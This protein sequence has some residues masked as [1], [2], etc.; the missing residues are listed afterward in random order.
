[1]A[2]DGRHSHACG[3]PDR[4]LSWSRRWSHGFRRFGLAHR[5]WQQLSIAG[6][7][8]YARIRPDRFLVSPR[9]GER[10]TG[11]LATYPQ[12]ARQGHDKMRPARVQEW[13][14]L[15]LQQLQLSQRQLLHRPRRTA[16]HLGLWLRPGRPTAGR[17]SGI[18]P[19]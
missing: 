2:Q 17:A 16:I 11:A 9:R 8:R 7:R 19:N 15:R 18:I 6:K 13:H 5:Q 1:M 10:R 12:A 4:P 14:P 3:L